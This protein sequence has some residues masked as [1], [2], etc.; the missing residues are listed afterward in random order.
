VIYRGD[1]P[2]EGAAAAVA[3]LRAAGVRI[4]FC[5]NN[6]ASRVDQYQEKLFRMGVDAAELEVL[7]SAVVTGEVLATRGL[8]GGR[9]FVIGEDGL[10][11]SV[12]AAGLVVDDD[13]RATYADVVAVG[14]DRSFDYAALHRTA[15]AVRTGAL[16]LATNDDTT[17]PAPGG[18]LWPGAGAI[19]ASAIGPRRICAAA[20]PRD[21]PPSSC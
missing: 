8:A 11:H 9:A 12:S 1:V 16:F 13:L 7:T 4:V 21:G 15:L 14:L 18:L 2:V 6:S 17:Y 10:R 20:R 19:L 3:R 5:T